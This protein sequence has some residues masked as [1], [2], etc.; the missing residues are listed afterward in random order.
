MTTV[1]LDEI[2][3]LH[4]LAEVA[5]KVRKTPR[6]LKEAAKRGEFEHIKIGKHYMFTTEQ[7]Q[8]LIRESTRGKSAPL[9]DGLDATRDRVARNRSRRARATSSTEQRAA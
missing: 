9:D 4:V 6:A 2:P 5:Q 8:R 7:V 1:D 3:D